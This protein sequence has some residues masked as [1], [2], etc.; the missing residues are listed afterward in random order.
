[1]QVAY[2]NQ[3]LESQHCTLLHL[4]SSLR[5]IVNSALGPIFY[6]PNNYIVGGLNLIEQISIKTV[7]F[8]DFI[9]K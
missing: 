8:F 4:R 9:T 6:M 5:H 1:M 7:A 3:L 2:T